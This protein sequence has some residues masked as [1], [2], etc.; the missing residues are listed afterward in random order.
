MGFAQWFWRLF[1][2]FAGLIVAHVLLVSLI[3][4]LPPAAGARRTAL[5]WMSAAATV[6]LGSLATWYCVRRIAEPLRTLSRD[7]RAIAAGEDRT[8]GEQS[9]DELGTL[10]DAFARMQQSL[11]RRVDQIQENNEQTQTILG[12]MV[13]GVLAVGPDRTILL[14]NEA[15]RNLLDFATPEPL[16]RS[17]LEV[18]RVRPVF[19]AVARALESAAPIVTEFDTPTTPRRTLSLRATRLP[20]DPCPGVMIVLHDMT[21]LRR[22]ENLR[23]ELVANVSHELNTPLSAIKAYAETL[24]LGGINDPEINVSFVTRIEE[25]ADRLLELIL[26]LLQIARVESGKETFEITSVEIAPVL[27]AC[28]DQFAERA[29]AKKIT[30]NVQYAP[31]AV[32]VMADEEGLR[33]ILNNL[34]DNAIK[35][36]PVGGSVTMSCRA[37]GEY[38]TLE[39]RDTGIGIAAQ[40]QSR[41]FERFYRID[42]ARSREL[43]GTGLGLSIVKHLVQAFG[44]SVRVESRP[45]HGATFHIQ[46]PR[47]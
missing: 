3:V 23:R 43:G 6:G 27:D 2:V 1:L 13:E 21:E 28:A 40:E 15:G 16:G 18:T 31:D 47:A 11:A 35:Y 19:E 12:S 17:L 37:N 33:T 36:T 44:G 30:L 24:R 8:V 42:K 29:A 38:V 45:G 14:A 7:V 9:P 41:I 39:V 46:L 22:L 20:G 5:M 32:K 25:Q 34:L 10:A 26:D 4:A